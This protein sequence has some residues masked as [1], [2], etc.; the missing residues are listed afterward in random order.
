MVTF[1]GFVNEEL[2]TGHPR[3]LQSCDYNQQRGS[4]DPWQ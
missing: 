4:F 2:G 1:Y 3:F